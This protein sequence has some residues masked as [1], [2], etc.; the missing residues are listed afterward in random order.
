MAMGG[1]RPGAGRPKGS[2][3]KRTLAS[4]KAVEQARAQ[5]EAAIASGDIEP[6]EGDAHAFL[7]WVYKNPVVELGDRIDAAGKAIRY[8]KPALASI[9]ATGKDGAPLHPSE[10]EIRIVDPE[11]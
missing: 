11:G 7:M 3:N 1:K 8:E 4:E 10:I 6:F 2:K 5:I 9:E